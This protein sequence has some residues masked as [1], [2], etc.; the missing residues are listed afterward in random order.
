MPVGTEPWR[1]MLAVCL[2][3]AAAVAALTSCAPVARRAGSAESPGP[4]ITQEQ[5][6]TRAREHLA[7]G[8]HEY[9]LGHYE[10][11]LD[12]LKASL[13]HGLL[14]KPEQSN[15]RKHL[16]FVH[17][18]EAREPECRDEF[19]K[20]LE[21]DPRFRL[22]PAEVGHP[23]WGPVYRSVRGELAAAT[24][25][26]ATKVARGPRSVAEQLLDKGMA[27]Y[28][29]GEYESAAKLLQSAVKEGLPASADTV[30]ALKHSAFSLCLLERYRPCREEFMKIFEVDP[31]FDLTVAEAGHPSWAKIFASASRRAHEETGAAAKVAAQRK[32]Q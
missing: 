20:A 18:V 24:S 31:G 1:R 7:F 2:A 4:Q 25:Q 17:C 27:Q 5:L 11:A 30:K 14:S 15:A 22:A 23:I 29:E 3:A 16:A 26:S 21:I 6:R 28:E 12:S 10:A 32:T 9:Q 13:D 19:R 8:L